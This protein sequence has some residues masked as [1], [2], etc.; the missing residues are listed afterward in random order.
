MDEDSSN[1]KS[2]SILGTPSYMA[3]EQAGSSSATLGP[4]ADVYAL[5]AILYHMLTG[6]PPFQAETQLDTIMQVIGEEPV[7]PRR[8]NSGIPLD[9]DTIALKC[10][11]KDPRRRYP[12]AAD[13]SE[14]LRRWLDGRPIMSRPVNWLEHSW[15][16]CKRKPVVAALSIA[17]ISLL[18]IGTIISSYFG[19]M[20]SREAKL[21][22][23]ARLQ[24]EDR[25]KTAHRY[26][27]DADMFLTQVDWGNANT[28]RMIETLSR[29]N[30]DPIRGFEWYYWNRLCGDD[31]GTFT[32]REHFFSVN[33]VV[34]NSDATEIATASGYLDPSIIIW[35][36]AKR[37]KRIRIDDIEDEDG[38]GSIAFSPD[39]ALII[40]GLMKGNVRIWRTDDGTLLRSLDLHE[41]E[42]T[43]ICLHPD[44]TLVASCSDDGTV[45]IWELSSGHV[46]TTITSD[47]GFNSVDFHPD[48][49]HILTSGNGAAA[50][51]WDVETGREELL[52]DHEDP[53]YGAAFSPS[54]HR[55]VTG[56]GNLVRLWNAEDGEIIHQMVGHRFLV[57]AVAFSPDGTTV[58]S[59]GHDNSVRLWEAATG[60]EKRLLKGHTG[61]IQDL[62][63]SA[64]GEALA[65]ASDDGTARVHDLTTSRE[66]VRHE[67]GKAP[68]KAL[69]V[70]PDGTRLLTQHDIPF[71]GT[72]VQLSS[73]ATGKV[74]WTRIHKDESFGA[75]SIGGEPHRLRFSPD[76]SLVVYLQGKHVVIADSRTGKSTSVLKGHRGA[77]NS[78]VFDRLGQLIATTSSFGEA[79]IWSVHQGRELF[80]LGSEVKNAEGMHFLGDG[81]HV[82]VS[83]GFG[84]DSEVFNATTGEKKR[85]LNLDGP[86]LAASTDTMQIAV[87]TMQ[88]T[89]A[90]WNAKTGKKTTLL[91][92]HV[93]TVRQVAFGPGGSRLLSTSDD[94]TVRLWDLATGREVLTFEPNIGAIQLADFSRNGNVIVV[95]G[96]AGEIVA[97]D[98]GSRTAK[99]R[100]DV[101]ARYRVF[102]TQP[103]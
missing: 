34:F 52:L 47:F 8:L 66:S 2:G 72:K 39:D 21:A 77:V 71:S 27:Y 42:V 93:D 99:R 48:G 44:G 70:S 11:E 38:V 28:E 20:A 45:K 85:S 30:D 90:I 81:N 87:G 92:G 53:V 18:M 101:P 32:M 73:L 59:G 74:V 58:A 67:P 55:I 50:H 103:D 60:V 96:E 19:I 14:D 36:A 9:L 94:G 78:V 62:R 91:S 57:G 102:I 33:A 86:C 12:S 15:R 61:A 43:S 23:A 31:Q 16:W 41:G 51:V 98:C 3:P 4:T 65:S 49:N 35:N 56:C 82:L 75:L 6:R 24:A 17:V 88:H 64:T 13:L 95:L 40:V 5:G 22:D 84:M 97:W 89:I 37:E 63:F 80:D 25:E 46:R 7:A 54:G 1:T 10:L 100:T 76:G 68:A 29:Y 83:S 69:A 79:K 26:A